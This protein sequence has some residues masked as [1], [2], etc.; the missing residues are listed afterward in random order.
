MGNGWKLYY[1]FVIFVRNKEAHGNM[2][3]F[4]LSLKRCQIGSLATLLH[5][6]TTHQ[7]VESWNL[8]SQSKCLIEKGGLDSI[9]LLYRIMIIFYR[10]YSYLDV[11]CNHVPGKNNLF[12]FACGLITYYTV[13][14]PVSSS[15]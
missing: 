9:N 5:N 12:T 11:W 15:P 8:F 14:F 1:E 13:A 10:L 3:I 7:L 6:L 2:I 4:V